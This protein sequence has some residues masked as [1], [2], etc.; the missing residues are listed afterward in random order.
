MRKNK[1]KIPIICFLIF[2]LSLVISIGVLDLVVPSHL[3]VSSYDELPAYPCVSVFDEGEEA[4][5]GFGTVKTVKAKLF[6]VL[7]LKEIELKKYE[8]VKLIPS[9]ETLGLKLLGDGVCV[10]GTASVKTE[11]GECSPAKEAGIMPRDVILKVNGTPIKTVAALTAFM[12]SSGGKTLILTCRRGREELTLRLTPVCAQSDG[13]YKSGMYVK[14]VSSGIGTVTFIDPKT[15]E[16]GAL[17][18]G[19][20]DKESG[21]LAP[22]SRGVVTD[23]VVTGVV[24]GQKGVPGELRGYLKNTKRGSLLKNTNAGVF[25]ALTDFKGE[26]IPIA[27]SSE[28]KTGKATL[29]TALD[30]GTPKDYEIE[31]TEI[32]NGATKSFTVRVTDPAL[33][34]KTGGI[35]QGMSGSPIIQNGKLIGAV[36][37]VMI[38]DPTAGY[39]I[40]IENMLSASQMPRNE[41]PVA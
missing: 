16:F 33:L 38:N 2:L 27:L 21:A 5:D 1:F 6:G 40:F 22:A 29:R 37:H 35:V 15:G 36:T 20:C 10:V 18:H 8:N 28:V 9:G 4:A 30:C 3:V 19:I 32:K 34:E 17:G 12:E 25:G 14:D 23:A 7:T 24:K 26:A 31:I 41:L 39:G 11:K 13:K